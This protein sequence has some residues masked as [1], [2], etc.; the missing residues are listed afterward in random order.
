MGSIIEGECHFRLSKKA[1]AK[2]SQR[3]QLVLF[4]ESM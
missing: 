4:D 3:L 1:N 2:H